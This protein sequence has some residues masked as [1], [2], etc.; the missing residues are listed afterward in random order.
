MYDVEEDIEQH[1]RK[2][3]QQYIRILYRVTPQYKGKNQIPTGVLI[4]AKGI[5]TE[6]N[7]CVFCYNVESKVKF[8]YSDGT[9]IEDNR[10]IAKN[11]LYQGIKKSYVQSK[12]R[13]SEN[14]NVNLVIDSQSKIYHTKNCIIPNDIDPKY[15]KD[16]TTKE[17]I[18]KDK[19]Y[20]KCKEC[21]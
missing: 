1:I 20:S 12:Q 19:V 18:I 13:K 11:K 16:I 15:I 9:I 8:N 14:G 10:I 4:E 7:V 6:Y 2:N 3:E 5:D 21:F 17:Q